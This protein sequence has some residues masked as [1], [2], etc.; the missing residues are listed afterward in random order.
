VLTDLQRRVRAIVTGLP[1]G[2]AVALAGGSALI[3]TEVVRR[4][5][6]DLDFFT[7]HPQ[8]VTSIL[9]A[10]ETRLEEAGLRVTRLRAADTYARLLV[11]SDDEATYVDLATDYQL[12]PALQTAEGPVLADRELAANKTL[13]LFSRAEA[14][15]YVDFQALAQRF[16][17]TELC[18]LASSKDGGFT[19]SLLAEALD[20]IDE[21]DRDTFDLDD[22]TYDDLVTFSKSAASELQQL[23]HIRDDP[24]E[25]TI[26]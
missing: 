23:T 2:A 25:L 8:P 4:G 3:V 9:D 13:A 11:E 24:D 18:D 16:T 6:G 5:T 20:Y 10:L 14:R 26:P 1:E 17:L 21:R 19:P 7:A 12:M 22:D 15:D